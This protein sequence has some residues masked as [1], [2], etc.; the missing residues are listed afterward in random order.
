MRNHLAFGDITYF[1][2]SKL[3]T[4]HNIRLKENSTPHKE[5]MRK[6]SPEQIEII[7][8]RVK[9]LIDRFNREG[10]W[11]LEIIRSFGEE[12]RWNLEVY[13]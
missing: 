7:E 5:G 3:F 9:E 8:K 11:I 2:T 10:H 13:C 12:E 4:N 6:K 1:G